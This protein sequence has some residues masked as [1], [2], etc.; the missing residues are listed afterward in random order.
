MM[1]VTIMVVLMM[2]VTIV[3]TSCGILIP[4][5]TYRPPLLRELARQAAH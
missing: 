4:V 5:L 1:T 2:V 3:D